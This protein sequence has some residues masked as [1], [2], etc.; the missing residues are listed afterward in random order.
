MRKNT[1]AV[2]RAAAEAA[3]KIRAKTE[4]EIVNRQRE[5]SEARDKAEDEIK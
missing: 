5:W 4:A 1:N 2:K 3:P